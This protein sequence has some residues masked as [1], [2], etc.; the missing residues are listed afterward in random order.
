MWIGITGIQP[1]FARA[2]SFAT[3]LADIR[4]IVPVF[5]GLVGRTVDTK[6]ALVYH[7]SRATIGTSSPLGGENTRRRNPRNEDHAYYEKRAP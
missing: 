1:L 3:L 4:G 6:L 7:V 5:H 2:E